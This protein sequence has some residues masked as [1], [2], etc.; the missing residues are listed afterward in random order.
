[1]LLKREVYGDHCIE[2]LSI[3]P[4]YREEY[5]SENHK[6]FIELVLLKLAR[7][8]LAFKNVETKNFN[9]SLYMEVKLENGEFKIQ[10]K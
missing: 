2:S 4:I 10:E 7:R 1:M 5:T 3:Y 8:Y 6:K 9:E